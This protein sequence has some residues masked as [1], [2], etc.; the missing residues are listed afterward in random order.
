MASFWAFFDEN[1]LR[2]WAFI[3]YLS[4]GAVVVPPI[5]TRVK[6]WLTPKTPPAP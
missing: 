1:W 3:G 4:V 6:G 5:I 2:I